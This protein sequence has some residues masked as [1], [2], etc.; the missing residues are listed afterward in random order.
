MSY[1]DALRALLKSA[2]VPLIVVYTMFDSYVDELTMQLA[3]SSHGRLDDE[4]LEKHA[5]SLAE[6]GVRERHNEITRLAGE[7]LPYVAVSSKCV[8]T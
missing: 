5:R 2:T 6:S 3:V 1:F 8:E 7:S 4:S